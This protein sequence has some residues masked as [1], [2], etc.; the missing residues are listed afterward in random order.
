MADAKVSK[1]FGITS[2][3]GSIP[4]IPTTF[5]HE[6]MD[7]RDEEVQV[8]QNSVPALPMK[9]SEI[10][11]DSI[12]KPAI[13]QTTLNICLKCA[14]DF[15]IKQLKLAPRTAY[16]E[17]KK[18]VPEEADFSGSATAR[19]H[20]F[21]QDDRTH[22]PYCSAPKRWFA[23]FHAFRIDSHPAFEKDRKRLWTALKKQGDRFTLWSPEL[24][25]MQIFS[26]WL[27]R[28]KRKI[29]LEGEA[30]LVELAVEYVKRFDP[31]PDWDELLTVAVR[32]VQVSSQL[33]S[34]WRYEDGWLYVSP[35]LYAE[36][37]VVQHLLSR[38][39]M[40]GGRTLEGRLTLQELTGRLRS[41]GYFETKGITTRD[42]YEAFEQ[43]IAALVA[44]NPCSVYYAVDRS[45]YLKQLKSVYEKKRTK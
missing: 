11:I 1:T 7:R 5:A 41:I 29:S 13:S 33:D 12:P 2:R 20:F 27:E 32:R 38:S 16:S 22:C 15:F 23:Q 4:T 44:S 21:N 6:A 34:S 19:P 9:K 45:D 24:S 37:L 10:N 28:M 14:F 36:I 25:Q 8:L 3:V 17:L 18:H 30:W 42:S 26:E 43:V 39:H 40:H 31:I 35:L